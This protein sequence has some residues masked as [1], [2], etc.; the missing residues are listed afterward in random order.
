MSYIIHIPTDTYF[1][2]AGFAQG[3]EPKI[4]DDPN[5]F[6]FSG[7]STARHLSD[8][9]ADLVL[10][11]ISSVGRIH[12]GKLD[13]SERLSEIRNITRTEFMIV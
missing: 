5:T 11:R 6:F 8:I 4:T 13:N 3:V 2:S 1:A 9:D 10:A 12:V 7:V